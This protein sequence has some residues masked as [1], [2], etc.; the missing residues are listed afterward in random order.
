MA[1]YKIFP[2]ND[3]TLYSS[4]PEMNTG[5]DAILEV[6][7]KTSLN[8]ENASV[9]RALI[10]F[11]Q[12]DINNIINNYV[13]E[14]N[15]SSS[16]NLYIAKAEGITF[17]FPIEI[18]PVYGYWYNGSGKYLNNPITTNGTSWTWL[19]FK[20]SNKWLSGSFP[21]NVTASFI[22]NNEGGGNW[23]DNFNITQSYGLKTFKDLHTNVT[24]I[25]DGWISSSI[26][27]NG[28]IIKL[29]DNIEFNNNE[30]LGVEFSFYSLDTNTIYP[31]NLEIKWDDF[32]YNT[33]SLSII[34]VP[35]IYVNVSN[36]KGKFFTDSINRFRLNVR[37]E[38]P[39][40]VYL[41]SSLYTQPNILPSSSFYAIKDFHTNEYIID[42]DEDFT[43][44]SC[45][46]QGN[47]FDIYMSGLQPERN[48]EI[49]IKTI[50]GGEVKIF[51][52]NFIF[53]VING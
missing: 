22:S 39:P 29:P 43:K 12:E 1:V 14:S 27:N 13:K 19:D 41:T 37:P 24:P 25:I 11:N 42:F 21:S 6:S 51:N 3:S 38:F 32:S 26:E 7:N 2:T 50:I 23:Y 34:D 36:N 5:I 47:Y 53:K 18:Y 28:F 15:W 33:G 31:P 44:I 40:R 20:D 45:D 52:D 9:S 17:D 10:R 49:L 16:L 46:E 4:F 48:Y 8:D 35:Q 30:A